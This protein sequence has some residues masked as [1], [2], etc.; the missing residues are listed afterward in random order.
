METPV[1]EMHE[2]S[3]LIRLDGVGKSYGSVQVLADA[4]FSVSR[5][6]VV[7][8]MGENGA[9]KSTLKNILCGLVAPSSGSIFVDGRRYARLTTDLARSI[10]IGAI[11]Q[12]LS[13]FPNLSVAENVHIG[14]GTL[15][16]RGVVIDKVKMRAQALK[17]LE[18]VFEDTVDPDQ[19]AEQLSLGE[20]QLVEVAKAMHRAST[21]LIF[22][23]PT[24]SLS[25]PERQRL[26]R[27]VRSLRD[28]GY[29]LVYV[30]HFMEEVYELANKIVVLRDGRIVGQSKPADIT[31]AQLA[32][33]MVGRELAAADTNLAAHR[34][35]AEKSISAPVVLRTRNLSDGKLLRDVTFDLHAGEVLGIGGLLGAGRTEIAQ[36]IFGLNPSSGD[37]EVGGQPFVDRS[38]GKA[39]ERG[40]AL[41][42]EDR[43]VEQVFGGRSVREN[44]TSTI[45]REFGSGWGLISRARQRKR[46]QE[47][48]NS[49]GVRHPGLDAPMSALSGGNQQK[50]VIA[51]WLATKPAVC[52]LDEPTK[53]IDVKAKAEVHLLINEL[54]AQGLGVLL[55]SSDLPEL[56]AV[57]HRILVMHK[58]LIV[59]KL[60]RDEFDPGSIVR[61]ASTGKA[62]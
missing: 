8:L 3:A 23:E 38:P 15:P 34:E 9:G 10:G 51:R 13:L 28:R 42:S 56:L 35:Q 40:I 49:F 4:S 54:A 32:T 6:E 48:S 50:C 1:A 30:T 26:F 43:R 58:G 44:L 39:K 60:E 2:E 36:A 33:L 7:A 5:G 22:D 41:V 37:V 12:E 25:L 55:I 45:I 52:I 46:A 14:V 47:L 57:S 24:T 53:G 62:A 19:L 27:V 29:A 18:T 31:P 17:V 59:G 20:R 61:I 16:M 11:H 21:M